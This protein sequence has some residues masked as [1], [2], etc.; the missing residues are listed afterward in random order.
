MPFKKGESANPK[1]RP[2]GSK[3]RSVNV[4]KELY[5]DIVGTLKE[6]KYYRNE[7]I[8]DAISTWSGRNNV[9]SYLASLQSQGIDTSKNVSF[10]TSSKAGTIQLAKAMSFHETGRKFSLSD[11]GWSN[12][13]DLGNSKGWL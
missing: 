2:K 4:Y 6:G 12:A 3:N 11:Q 1:G 9:N 7:S 8:H 5:E 13:Y 10:Y